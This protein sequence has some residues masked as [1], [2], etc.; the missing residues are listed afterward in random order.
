MFA[1]NVCKWGGSSVKKKNAKTRGSMHSNHILQ[2][3]IRCRYYLLS[4]LGAEGL[5]MFSRI[6]VSASIFFIL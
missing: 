6:E 5:A 4:A 3:I 1:G 2:Y